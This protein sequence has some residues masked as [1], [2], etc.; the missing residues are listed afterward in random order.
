MK[1]AILFAG[2]VAVTAFTSCKK[3]TG[4]APST[5][6][7]GNTYNVPGTY[8]F[9]PMNYSGQTYRQQ[10]LD[11]MITYMKTARTP[12]TV[13]SAATL[14][15]MFSN[16]NSPFTNATLNTCG[17]Q[18]ESKCFS[19]DVNAIKAYLD[20]IAVLSNNSANIVTSTTDNT[21][22]YVLSSEGIDYTELFEKSVMGAVFYYQA[23]ETYL[24]AAGV[25]STVDNTTVVS[26]EGTAME[27][28]WDEGF[29]YLGVPTDFPG[30]AAGVI[31]WGEYLDEIGTTL[32]NKSTLMNAFIKGRAAISNKDYT[33]RDAQMA[34]INTEW[35][36]LI[37]ASAIHE[38]N[39]AKAEFADNAIRNHVLSEA[40]GFITSLKY[41][42][43]KVMTQAQIDSALNTLGWNNNNTTIANINLVIDDL[44]NA[45]GLQSVK[46]I[47]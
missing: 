30:N 11:E 39:E 9:S 17:K 2:L 45:Y 46:N 21:K 33:T 8:T 14:K 22:K 3:D 47:L 43:N 34:I 10:M 41:K 15:D 6:S 23:M 13:L 20:S 19:L 26:G 25:G 7:T 32:N 5:P 29:G 1:K 4:P 36:K 31:F 35:E 37:A 28:H 24:C 40:R 27:H 12:G 18:L 16:S 44:A 42:T 38:L